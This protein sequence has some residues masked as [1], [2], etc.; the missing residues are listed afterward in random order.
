MLVVYEHHVV[1]YLSTHAAHKALGHGI[2]IRRP[3][4]RSDHLRADALRRTVECQAELVVA[5]P[6]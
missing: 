3:N 5:I 6:Q 4:R 1:E 2:H